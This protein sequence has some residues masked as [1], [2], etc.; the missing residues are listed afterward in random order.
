MVLVA[1][2]AF[3]VGGCCLYYGARALRTRRAIRRLDD[4]GDHLGDPTD[5][6]DPPSERL[7]SGDGDG[8][9]SADDE[10][11]VALADDG[12]GSPETARSVAASDPRSDVS[13]E[14]GFVLLVLGVVCLL[15]GFFAL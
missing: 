10:D 13:I 14:R 9:A 7:E 8:S 6:L 3:A 5:W 15:F 4:E 2:V 12:R 11:G 1:A